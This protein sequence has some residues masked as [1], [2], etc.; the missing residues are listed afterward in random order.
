MNQSKRLYKDIV[1]C[2][3]TAELQWRQVDKAAYRTTIRNVDQASR[4]FE[5]TWT[6]DNCVWTLVLV[7]KTYLARE[8]LLFPPTEIRDAKLF[9]FEGA[10][11]VDLLSGTDLNHVE[12]SWLSKNI[13]YA[14]QKPPASLVP[15]D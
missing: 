10:K 3:Q 15:S 14:A 4:V 1:R 7:E 12:T 6:K 9:I 2:T 5:A 13:A 11:L 8:H